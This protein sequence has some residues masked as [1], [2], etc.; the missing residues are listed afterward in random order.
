[1]AGPE[2]K[3]RENIDE[4]LAKAGWVVCDRDKANIT[5]RQGVGI[6]YLPLKTEHGNRI[7]QF[8]T[9]P[10]LGA[11]DARPRN[12]LQKNVRTNLS[13]QR[14]GMLIAPVGVE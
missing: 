9:R 6:R 11:Q 10:Q 12:Q 2:D 1:M 13:R 8:K 4:L 14:C 5:A 7:Q 3:A